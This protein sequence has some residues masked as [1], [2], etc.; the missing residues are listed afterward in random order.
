MSLN[1]VPEADIRAALSQHRPSRDDFA[2]GVR[3]RLQALELEQAKDPLCNMPPL[4]RA[5]AA[6]LPLDLLSAGKISGATAPFVPMSGMYKFVQYLLLP[7]A[8]L[9]V[10]LGAGITTAW[11][12][13]S[14]RR[15]AP[16]LLPPIE[17]EAA[18]KDWWSSHQYVYA[19]FV[20][21]T[22]GISIFGSTWPL[23]CL[24]VASFALLIYVINSLA[25]L[26][27]GN[28]FLIAQWCLMGLLLLAQ[29]ATSVEM[30]RYDIHLINQRVVGLV[31][32]VGVALMTIT[33]SRES[34]P[35]R[36]PK[37]RPI[38]RVAQWGVVI[39]I[40]IMSLPIIFLFCYVGFPRVFD[41]T[42]AQI[43]Q[44]VESFDQAPFSTASWDQWE[45]PA[46]WT[47]DQQMHPDLAKPRQLLAKE[48]AGAQN[49]FILGVA[50]RTGLLSGHELGQMRN[51]REELRDLVEPNRYSIKI[52]PIS[53]PAQRDWVIRAAVLRGEL[54]N[55][56]RDFLAERLRANIDDEFASEYLKLKDVLQASQLLGVIGRASERNAYHARVHAALRQFQ[57]TSGWFSAW[58]GFRSFRDIH[59]SDLNATVCAV[60][61]MQIY[62]VPEGLNLDWV[63]SYLKPSGFYYGPR[64]ADIA[65]VTLARLNA[66]P[67]VR[68]PSWLDYLYYERSLLAAIVLVGL[69]AYAVYISPKPT[70]IPPK[71]S[72]LTGT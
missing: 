22:I 64:Q 36:L 19:L 54:S 27:L 55:A 42:P 31:F 15:D 30:G 56:Q 26:G 43:K 20:A 57:N 34:P 72:P 58:G 32:W 8:S 21:V 53:S 2:A 23:Y 41:P 40:A 5:A 69:C 14:I 4:A 33:V 16:P 70:P 65:A 48:I 35:S 38:P 46:Q 3:F 68:P 60:E 17:T 71:D 11:K 37:Q 7:A 61:L 63:R 18:N 12:L 24:Y 29:T 52:S 28:R 25:K 13:R 62:G 10:L 6:I 67:G 45:T 44:Y 66:I 47:I 51:Y 1:L 49:P 39:A 59:S 50:T 9:F